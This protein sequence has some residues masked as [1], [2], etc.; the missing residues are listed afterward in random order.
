LASTL[1]DQ[2]RFD[3]ALETARNAVA[4]YRQT[5]GTG[6]PDFG[7]ALTVLGGLLTEKGDFVEAD[8]RLKEGEQIL[9]QLQSPTSLWLGDNLR[10][11][12]ISFY[13]QGKYAESQ[14]RITET[15]KIYLEGFGPAYDQY[16]TVLIFKGLI[17]DKTGKSTEGERIL[18]DA[19]KLRTDSL[20]KEHFWVAVAKGALGE[21]LMTQKRFAEA[22][23]LLVE[24]YVS[25]NSHLGKADPRTTEASRRLVT[26]YD[27][28]GKPMQA[29]QYRVV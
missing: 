26:L 13:R 16:P 19:V 17:L 20:P 2:G 25:L 6:T 5:G 3:E 29:A 12:A 28:W 4:E 9:R 23:P 1:A 11:Q 15:E 21:C 10:N 24:T 22:E 14:S 8:A 27:L 7:F 18:R